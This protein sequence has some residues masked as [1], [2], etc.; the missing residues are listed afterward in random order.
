VV[1]GEL[2]GDGCLH[3]RQCGSYIF[4]IPT[5]TKAQARYL[6]DTLPDG[7]FLETQPNSFTRS[8]ALG[9]GA[10]TTWHFTSRP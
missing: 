7:L 8:N 1:E 10:Y 4:Q 9:E 6:M 3:H 5:T 2:L